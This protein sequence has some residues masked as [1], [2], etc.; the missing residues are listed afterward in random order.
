MEG[1]ATLN[2]ALKWGLS[3]CFWVFGGRYHFRASLPLLMFVKN[4]ILM[5]PTLDPDF[6]GGG[7]YPG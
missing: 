5:N 7:S 6:I 2:Q 4:V 1:L 3:S